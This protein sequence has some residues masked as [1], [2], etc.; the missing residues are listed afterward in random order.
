[1]STI[2]AARIAMNRRM[3]DE[4]LM[5]IR[6]MQSLAPV[7]AEAVTAYLTRTRRITTTEHEVT[8][9]LGYLADKGSLKSEVEWDAGAYVPRYFITAKGRD[10]LDG[11][12]PPDA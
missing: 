8:D 9:R 3:D 6:E 12:L 2:A 7:T 5:F 4:I 11:A 10:I 1:M